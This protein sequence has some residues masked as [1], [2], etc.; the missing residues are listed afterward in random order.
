MFQN[1][2]LLPPRTMQTGCCCK[3]RK[4]KKIPPHR[5]QCQCRRSGGVCNS[6]SAEIPELAGC[7]AGKAERAEPSLRGNKENKWN[8]MKGDG[9]E[10]WCC[11][12]QA[13]IPIA[14]TEDI[15]VPWKRHCSVFDQ[16]WSDRCQCQGRD[17]K[18]RAGTN[19]TEGPTEPELSKEFTV[20]LQCLAQPQTG[21]PW[22]YQTQGV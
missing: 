13:L 3:E 18:H 8:R 21:S 6:S 10:L 17:M 15:P 4:E 2:A 19:C 12:S 14:P 5:G 7:P 20:P 22:S 11:Q 9:R 1:E 16:Q